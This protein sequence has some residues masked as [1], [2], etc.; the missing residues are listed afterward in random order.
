MCLGFVF[1]DFS[2]VWAVSLFKL[3]HLSRYLTVTPSGSDLLTFLIIH[4]L[5]GV[6]DV[7]FQLVSFKL[8][9][10]IS[11][12]LCSAAK[13]GHVRYLI[14]KRLLRQHPCYF[15]LYFQLYWRKFPEGLHLSYFSDKYG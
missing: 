5:A 4:V 1:H 7:A 9:I 13:P 6:G 15:Q 10:S 12:N 2:V 11:K 14:F 3:G 8:I